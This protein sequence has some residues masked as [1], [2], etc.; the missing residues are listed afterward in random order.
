METQKKQ[1]SFV[2]V[3]AWFLI[4]INGLG[5]LI[6]IA[7]N[8]MLQTFMKDAKFQNS[9]QEMNGQD[10]GFPP[11][12]SSMFEHMDLMVMGT[13][14]LAIVAFVA[15]IALLKRKNWARLFFIVLFSLAIVWSLISFYMQYDLMSSMSAGQDV[16][17]NFATMQNTM[18]MVSGA[19]SL[20]LIALYVYLIKRLRSESIKSEFLE[21]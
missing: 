8:I 16:P 2:K 7:Q 15:S 9:M 21:A 5:V 1:S 3:L 18:M 12:M 6:G 10:S 19:I 20:A 13:L 4:V 17:A 11:L 14:A